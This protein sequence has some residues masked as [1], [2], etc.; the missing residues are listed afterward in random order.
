MFRVSPIFLGFHSGYEFLIEY[1]SHL[2]EIGVNHVGINL[3][4]GARLAH[5]VVQNLGENVVQHF[6]AFG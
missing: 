5:E 2:N 3:K 4:D 1:L 6:P